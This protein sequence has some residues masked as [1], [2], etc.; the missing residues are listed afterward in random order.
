[1]TIYLQ[2][3][4]I[5][6]ECVD[7]DGNIQ[8]SKSAEIT[9]GMN[10]CLELRLRDSDGVPWEDLE[11]YDSWEF[12][13]GN[14]W[15][16]ATPVLLAVT[17]NITA[18]GDQVII[19]VTATNTA[20]LAAALGNSEK[21][22]LHA[23]LLGFCSDM[24][25]PALVIQFDIT[26]RNRVALSGTESPSELPQ[27]YLTAGAVKA[28][29]AS[30]TK[31]NMPR[32]N[33]AGTWEVN[34]EDTGVPATGAQGPQGPQGETGPQGV[35]GE[36]GEQGPQGPQGEKGEQGPQGPQ[37]PAGPQGEQG[38]QGIQGERGPAFAFDATG[39][40]AELSS[41]DTKPEG[42]SFYATDTGMFYI[43][44][45]DVEG[46]WSNPQPFKGDK[47]DQG[48]QGPQG[49]KG[50]QGV[51]G[52][53]ANFKLE[54]TDV[55]EGN[56]L[57]N[58]EN[59]FPVAVYTSKGNCYPIEKESIFKTEKGWGVSSAKYLAYDNVSSFTSPWF[60]YCA[61]GVKGDD[62]ESFTPDV[63]GL[64]S[65]KANYDA[66]SK[67]FA[68]LAI[69]EGAMYFK[70]SDTDGDWSEAIPFRGEQGEP[71]QPGAKGEKGDMAEVSI[72]D[73]GNWIVNGVD[74][75]K[76]SRGKG[77]NV[78]MSPTPPAQPFEGMIYINA[79]GNES[80]YLDL[81]SL[82]VISGSTPP[83]TAAEGTVFIVEAE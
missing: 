29:V 55:T 81:E 8:R 54:V 66:E 35:Q 25:A 65:E 70:L 1:M 3:N 69:D 59:A 52:T 50:E 2:L 76:S 6:G 21:I 12:Y 28:L 43:K 51:P 68:F 24:S 41:Y 39:T 58:N 11:L 9:R 67:G 20:E 23:E 16:P 34:G 31:H 56:I 26:V 60:V 49:E 15:D 83:A 74:T 30:E 44:T 79:E 57:I 13:A 64:L 18:A 80:K 7:A 62:G 4:G 38:I 22:A 61:G 32:I 19:P 53:L 10:A 33:T 27:I 14:D 72:A 45:S 82:P 71:G 40:S 46:D 78:I 17:E 47:G 75:G 5:K 37:G 63:R 77:A 36:K 48:E 42:F 73:N